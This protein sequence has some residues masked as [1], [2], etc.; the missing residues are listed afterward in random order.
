MHI[1]CITIH[2]RYLVLPPKRSKMHCIVGL[3]LRP[4]KGK[5]AGP[6]L[7]ESLPRGPTRQ[8]HA[9]GSTR[10][11]AAGSV[12]SG[13]TA[14]RP[15]AG[16]SVRVGQGRVGRARRPAQVQMR[17]NLGR[18]T[19][20]PALSRPVRLTLCLQLPPHAIASRLAH[21]PPASPPPRIGIF[22]I[23]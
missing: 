21:L 9:L 1:C 23:F 13:M 14:A 4:G 18:R 3:S 5:G 22:F 19:F 6:L 20:S 10:R 15:P 2:T 7:T 8:Q 16:A 17:I 11:P 12:G